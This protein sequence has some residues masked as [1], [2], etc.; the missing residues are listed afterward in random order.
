MKLVWLPLG[1][2][3]YLYWQQTDKKALKRINLLIKET[4]RQPFEGMG[5]PEPLK[6]NFSGWWSR[7]ITGEHRL[8]YKAEDDRLIIMKCR[9]HY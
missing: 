3:D 7:R 8:V 5:K 2:E 9:Y 4:I 1:W 6:A